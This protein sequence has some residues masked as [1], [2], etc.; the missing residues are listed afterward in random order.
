VTVT[1]DQ[2]RQAEYERDTLAQW[3][4]HPGWE[5]TNARDI[6]ARERFMGNLAK[7]L[8]TAKPDAVIDQQEIAFQRGRWRG[9][10][11]L[12]NEIRLAAGKPLPKEGDDA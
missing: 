6:E 11:E 5:I 2:D 4:S 8:F 9:R 3:G 7:T 1:S 10:R 12:M